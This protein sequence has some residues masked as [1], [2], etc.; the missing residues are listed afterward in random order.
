LE[1]QQ[2]SSRALE[3]PCLNSNSSSSS[4]LQ[5]DSLVSSGL[6]WGSSPSSSK[7]LAKQGQVLSHSSRCEAQ[8]QLLGLHNVRSPSS[9]LWAVPAAARQQEC[10][11]SGQ[12]GSSSSSRLT[13]LRVA[14]L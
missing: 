5:Q 1:L 12:Q 11:H 4:R 8:P 6:A 9:S 14:G 10:Q 3:A 13:K 7:R 2:G